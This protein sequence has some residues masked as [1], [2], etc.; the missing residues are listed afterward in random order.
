MKPTTRTFIAVEIGEG[1]RSAAAKLIRRFEGIT[2][3]IRWVDIPNLHYT[4]KFCGEIPTIELYEL[5][6]TLEDGLKSF[7]PFPLEAVGV[8]AFPTPT[9][10]R[11]VWIGARNGGEQLQKLHER[12]NEVLSTI[13]YP[14]DGRALQPHL[15]LGRVRKRCKPGPVLAE[16][17]E[18]CAEQEFGTISIDEVT[19]FAS[20]L[21]RRGPKY[22]VIGTCPLQGDFPQA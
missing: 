15:T 17:I 22:E 2:D 1:L 14:R 11:T 4:L 16:L 9:N 18:E 6:K 7:E 12:I 20:E 10:P 5:L 19:V 8:G 21:M 13:G 3:D